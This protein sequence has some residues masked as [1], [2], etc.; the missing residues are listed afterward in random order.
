MKFLKILLLSFVLLST[1]T[2]AAKAVKPISVKEKKKRFFNTMV[3]V[4]NSVYKELNIQY[5]DIKKNIKNPKYKKKIVALKKAYK[6]KTDK[7]LLMALKP[8]PR[9]IALAQA[10]LESAWG[11]SRFYKK[12]NNVFGVWSFN[13]KEPRIAASQKRGKKTVWLKKYPSIRES[14]KDYYKNL[15]RSH[16]FV[17]FRELKMKTNDPYKLVKKLNRYSEMKE[18][19]TKELATIIKFN[20][21]QKYDRP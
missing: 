1:N 6:I 4:V 17:E 19:Y 2:L 13:K 15:S 3:P 7:Q 9:S 11:T 21:L 14:V 20:K 8:H 5:K 12:A 18:S 10:V 16:A